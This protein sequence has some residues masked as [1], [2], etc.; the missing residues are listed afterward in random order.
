[1]L[2]DHHQ[3]AVRHVA[4]LAQLGGTRNADV[5]GMTARS[6]AVKA[7]GLSDIVGD[8]ELAQVVQQ[9]ANGKAVHF[10]AQGQSEGLRQENA[11]VGHIRGM[12]KCVIVVVAARPAGSRRSSHPCTKQFTI[13]S[14][15]DRWLPFCRRYHGGSIRRVYCGRH[16]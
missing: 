11:V 2:A 9:R 7:L 5:P 12:G 4:T 16:R 10:V 14:D 1:M 6:T 13:Q 15:P 3:L 8:I